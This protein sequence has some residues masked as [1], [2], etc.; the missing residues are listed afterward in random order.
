MADDNAKQPSDVSP[1]PTPTIHVAPSPH[2]SDYD[3]TTKRMMLDVLIGLAPAFAISLFVFRW[4]AVFQLG[5]SVLTCIFVEAITSRM[6][7]R[8]IPTGDYSAVVCGTILAFSLPCGAPWYVPVIGAAVAIGLGKAAFGGLGFNLFNP[9]MV[10][11]AFIM[12][13]FAQAMGA[14]GYVQ[15]Q[16]EITVLTQATPLS[17]TKQVA[18]NMLAGNDVPQELQAQ[19][20]ESTR[21]WDLFIGRTNGSIGETSTL[22]LLLGGV[23]LCLRRVAAWQIPLSMIAGGIVCGGLAQWMGLTPVSVLHQLASGAFILGAF[24]IATDPVT[25]PMAPRGRAIFGFGVG[26]FTIL[27]RVLSGY[28]EGVMFAILLMNSMTPLINRW[29]IPKP[30]G[31]VAAPASA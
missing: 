27:I 30:L 6:R 9:A 26:A 20:A 11:R 22:A 15:Q 5:I 8:P 19:L 4:F 28:P 7:G 12:L 29:T 2:L 21:L 14:G 13:S 1:V 17:V 16:S 23:Y 24:F 25:S 31:A 3:F 10:G 18:G